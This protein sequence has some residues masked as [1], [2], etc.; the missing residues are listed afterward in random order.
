M[1]ESGDR[2]VT[3][4]P[5]ERDLLAL[6]RELNRLGVAYLVIG[7]F[8]INRLG[9]V[10]ATDDL[11]LLIARDR[12][13]QQLVKQ[14]LE[15]LPDKAVRELGEEDLAQWV[16][17]RVNDDITIDLMTEA[18]GVDYESAK[19]GIEWETIAGVRIPFAG[20]ELM[21][22][23]KQGWREKDAS[24]RSFLQNLVAARKRRTEEERER[25]R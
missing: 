1:E 7:G 4:V 2:D 5:E 15:I 23:L 14:A 8:A 3:R 12:A 11:D 13:N 22:K 20:P 10:R 17:V 24:D 25:N 18:C 6:A 21:L 19:A 16:V 9:Y